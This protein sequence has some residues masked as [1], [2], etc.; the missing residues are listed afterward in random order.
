MPKTTVTMYRNEDGSVPLLE[1]LK[2]RAPRVQSKCTAMIALLAEK[3]NELRRPYA[4][5]FRDGIYEL[6]PTVGRV[7]Y[8]VLYCFAGARVVLL[9][10]GLVKTDRVPPKEIERARECRRRFSGDPLKHTFE[11]RESS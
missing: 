4:D 5:Y 8:R 2:M 9:T 3:G 1:W 6:R 7:H 11:L 10:H